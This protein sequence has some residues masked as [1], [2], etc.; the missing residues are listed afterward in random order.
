MDLKDHISQL[1]R[2][3]EA[4]RERAHLHLCGGPMIWGETVFPVS[5]AVGFSKCVYYPR[6]PTGQARFLHSE[7]THASSLLCHAMPTPILLCL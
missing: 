1:V 3:Q 4:L 7:L 6:L 5:Y 2:K